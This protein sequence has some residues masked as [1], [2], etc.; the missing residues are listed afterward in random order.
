MTSFFGIGRTIAI[1]RA[2]RRTIRTLRSLSDDA[3]KDIGLERY[4]ID[5]VFKDK[6]FMNGTK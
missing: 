3:L 4:Q 5:S 1:A 6:R 2:R